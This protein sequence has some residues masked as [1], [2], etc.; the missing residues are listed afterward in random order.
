VTV[1]THIPVLRDEVVAAIAPRAGDVFVDCTLGGGGHAEALLEAAD[2]Q[3]I[4]LDRD[5]AALASATER[6]ARFGERF[7][8]VHSA[9]S[10][11]R[12]ALRSRGIDR[13]D[14]ILADLGVSSHQL[15][16]AERGFSFRKSGPV[17]MRMDPGAPL[18]AANLVND[19]PENELADLIFR[20]G[21]E[22]KSRR[23]AKAIVAGR[24]W[25]D[26]AAL[27]DA[28]AKVVGRGKGRIHPATRTFQGLRIAVNDEIG[29][30]ATLLPE[31]VDMLAAGGRLAIITFH[32]LEDR[33]V[34]Q[35]LA[36]E[37]GKNRPRDAWGNPIGPVRLRLRKPVTPSASDPNPRSRSA[38]LRSAEKLPWNEPHQ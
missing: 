4:G 3:L 37:A 22:R 33:D 28:I 13:V 24:P 7:Q 26:T 9:F 30:L 15:D 18:S 14:A 38:R 19:T 17:D 20:F 32:S 8:P 27:A 31:A 11:I 10:G 21:E 34:K 29:E 36:D 16:T 25:S 6:L 23:V 12:A 2:I 1:Y 35:F 5:P